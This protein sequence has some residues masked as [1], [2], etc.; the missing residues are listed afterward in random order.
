MY[1]LEREKI[2]GLRNQMRDPGAAVGD[3]EAVRQGFR[4]LRDWRLNELTN[5]LGADLAEKINEA[6][7]QR[8]G[9]GLGPGGRR[10]NRGRGGQGVGTDGGT[11]GGNR[12]GGG[13]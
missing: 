1:I 7:F 4:D 13:L 8:F 10:G 2:D 11:D 3:P 6:D 9:G 5:R 12:P